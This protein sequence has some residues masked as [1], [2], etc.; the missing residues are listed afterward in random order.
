MLRPK[1]KSKSA[2]KYY[3]AYKGAGDSIV[4]ALE[5]L[6]IDSSFANRK[7][8]AE[9]NRIASYTGTPRQNLKMLDLLKQGKLLKP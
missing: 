3:K 2:S 6:K 9:K 7:K 4:D 5:S 1:K 8:I